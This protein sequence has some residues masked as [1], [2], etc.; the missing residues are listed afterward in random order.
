MAHP[1]STT[2]TTTT[3]ATT[4][5]HAPA[6]TTFTPDTVSVVIGGTS[7]IGR[8]VVD[9]LSARP[10][11]V[12]AAGLTTGLDVAD[13]SAVAAFF[14]SIGPVDHVVFT[15][16]SQAP[17]GPVASL[18]LDA[19]KAAFDIKF[20][21]V[22]AVARAA[23]GR[24]RPGGTLTLTSGFL[25]RRAVPGA[26]VK[27]AMNAAL[28]ASAKLLARE[29]AP[30]RVNVVSPGLTDTEAYAGMAPEARAAMLAKAAS[31]LPAGRAGQVQD[32]AAG[33]L[34]LIDNPFVT[35]SV[36]DIDGG[37]LIQ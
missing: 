17:G 19:A 6:G 29:L 12:I 32:L 2:A 5:A 14:E 33:Y 7:G 35:G 3:T 1:A 13:P 25:A 23:A 37:A 31:T 30:L 28:E 15:A 34:F 11:R 27:T 18:D 20:W 26:F 4:L 9:A 16:G 36:I 10:G 22:I 24:L 21:G 8:A